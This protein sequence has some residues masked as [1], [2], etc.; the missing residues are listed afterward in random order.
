MPVREKET[1]QR[2][3]V[4]IGVRGRIISVVTHVTLGFQLP[5]SHTKVMSPLSQCCAIVQYTV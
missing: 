5:F 3:L 4:R 1:I 2:I